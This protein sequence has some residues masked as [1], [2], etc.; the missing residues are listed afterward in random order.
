[1]SHIL[2]LIEEQI[3]SANL[4]N[5]PAEN[6]PQPGRFVTK[7]GAALGPCLLISRECGG[8]GTVLAQMAGERLGWNVFDSKIVDEIAQSAHVEQ[9]LIKN[10]DEHIHS[11][12]EQTWRGV[13]LGDLA[14]ERY[15]KHL[16]QILFALASQGNVVIVGRGAQFFF[17]AQC[18]LRVRLVAP[19]EER[20]K[21]VA[22]STKLPHD[23]ARLKIDQIDKERAFF[24]SKIF[25][26]D[27]ALPIY[28]DLIINTG[29]ID[30]RSATELVL[31]ALEMKLG[32][33]LKKPAG[34]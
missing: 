24:C 22:E 2:N 12:W 13:L 10:V 16:R 6:R 31:A 19:L 11:Y 23:Q 5:R 20:V 9:R 8:G 27:G 28:Y 25:K 17:P 32:V 18:A 7:E 1:M 21:R 15:F 29:Q 33:P 3:R 4:R 34:C 14:E 26:I 30:L